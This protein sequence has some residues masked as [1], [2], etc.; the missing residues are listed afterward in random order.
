LRRQ[1]V[2]RDGNVA[3]AFSNPPAG[4]EN[5]RDATTIMK[6]FVKAKA[7]AKEEKIEKLSGNIFY[8][9]VREPPVKDKANKAIVKALAGYFQISPTQVEIITGRSSKQKLFEINAPR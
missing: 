7:G 4:G 9:A 1:E 8:V 6:I 2:I 5:I 3:V